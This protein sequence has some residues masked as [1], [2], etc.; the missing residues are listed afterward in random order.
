MRATRIPLLDRQIAKTAAQAL[1]VPQPYP[2]I[3]Q[4]AIDPWLLFQRYD[5]LDLV[6]AGIVGKL[7]EPDK[8]RCVAAASYWGFPLAVALAARLCVSHRVHPQ[9]ICFGED[10]FTPP[11]QVLMSRLTSLQEAVVVDDVVHRGGNIKNVVEPEGKLEKFGFRPVLAVVVLDQDVT[12]DRR[13]LND[14]LRTK[15]CELYAVT[16]TTLI[17]WRTRS[18]NYLRALEFH[19]VG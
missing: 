12:P 10:V 19:L 1:F 15:P 14:I 3:P 17:P 13:E 6:T 16:R 4:D 18:K 2:H 7:K 11:K 9:C 5:L 8:I